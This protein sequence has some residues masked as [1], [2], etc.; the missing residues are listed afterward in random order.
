MSGH[1]NESAE[2][3]WTLE[4]AILS[5][6]E[7]YGEIHTVHLG[8]HDFFFRLLSMDEYDTLRQI[9]G[10]P[11]DLEELVVQQA[12]LEPVIEDLTSDIFAGIVTTLAVAILEESMIRERP[13]G[14]NNVKRVIDSTVDDISRR[15]MRQIPLTITQAFPAYKPT[16]IKEMSLKQQ[17][18]LYSEAIW[19]LTEIQGLEIDIETISN[20]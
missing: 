16:E 1:E 14:S 8:G 9:A 12:L 4:E 11:E 17:I 7:T 3:E 18:D 10:T 20:G 2:Q 13:D 19:V 15:L 5:W 6:K